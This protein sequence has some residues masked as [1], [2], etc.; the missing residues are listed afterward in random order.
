MRL[1]F[2]LGLAQL[3]HCNLET[4]LVNLP[5]PTITR[6]APQALWA[7]QLKR[8]PEKRQHDKSEE[9]ESEYPHVVERT[10]KFHVPD[11]HGEDHRRVRGSRVRLERLA[12]KRDQRRARQEHDRDVH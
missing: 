8:L 7:A 11:L 12:A 6:A 2:L 5:F 10:E 3:F 4:L 9:S 1:G